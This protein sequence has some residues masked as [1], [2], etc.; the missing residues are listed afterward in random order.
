MLATG[1][2]RAPRNESEHYFNFCITTRFVNSLIK[3]KY[4]GQS[5]VIEDT[6]KCK[7][8]CPQVSVD[9]DEGIDASLSLSIDIH[10]SAH[11]NA[12]KAL[13]GLIGDAAGIE[14]FS[15]PVELGPDGVKDVHSLGQVTDYE[16]KLLQTAANEL[17][18]NIE[19]VSSSVKQPLCI[20]ASLGDHLLL[21]RYLVAM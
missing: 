10:V 4:G 11:P 16:K 7:P 12:T 15:L 21:I 2:T 8:T 13:S 9:H 1:E 18:G 5:G 3:A 19:K 6:C 20:D 14:F 17:K